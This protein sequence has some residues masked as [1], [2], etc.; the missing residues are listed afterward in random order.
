MGTRLLDN[1][2]SHQLLGGTDGQNFTHQV[3]LT[4]GP[5]GG[6]GLRK[7]SSALLIIEEGKTHYPVSNFHGQSSFGKGVQIRG[8]HDS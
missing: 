4:T 2:G 6:S 8:F 5:D 3:L 7:V 1:F